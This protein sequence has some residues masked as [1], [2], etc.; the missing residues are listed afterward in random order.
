ME[1]YVNGTLSTAEISATGTYTIE[2]KA[3]DVIV[4]R[5]YAANI[6]HSYIKGITVTYA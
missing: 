5:G 2:A 1:V 4:V 6:S 3:N